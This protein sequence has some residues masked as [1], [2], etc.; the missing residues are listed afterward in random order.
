MHLKTNDKYT[1]NHQKI[2]S[3]IEKNNKNKNI[4][5]RTQIGYLFDN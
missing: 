3:L 1:L 2:K 4:L 5:F